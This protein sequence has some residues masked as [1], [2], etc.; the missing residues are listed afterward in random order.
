MVQFLVQYLVV[1]LFL[2]LS[3]VAWVVAVHEFIYGQ[4]ASANSYDDLVLFNLDKQTALAVG[5]DS[6]LLSHE[7]ETCFLISLIIVDVLGQSPINRVIFKWLVD[8][9]NPL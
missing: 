3:N 1:L 7:E 5:I 6:F 9:I 4:E 2:S 8:Q